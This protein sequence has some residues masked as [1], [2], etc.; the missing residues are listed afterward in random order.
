MENTLLVGLSRQV[1]L[2]R[3]LG[4]IANNVANMNT[5]GFKADKSLF[6]EY[7]N[8]GAR[9][10]NFVGRDRLV[11]FV[12]DRAATIALGKALFWDMRVGSDAKTACASCHFHAGA[13]PRS[14]NQL[15]RGPNGT[16]FAFGGPNYQLQAGDFPFHQ[17]SDPNN[18]DSAVIR[19]RIAPKNLARVVDRVTFSIWLQV[20]FLS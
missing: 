1:A 12:Q 16:S 9:E 8:S 11:S 14:K 2:E 7:L 5:T 17:F 15:S 20:V 10:D 13:D 4:V 6:E 3:Q 19:S 18:R